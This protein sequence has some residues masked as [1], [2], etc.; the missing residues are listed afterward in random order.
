MLMDPHALSQGRA[1]LLVRGGIAFLIGVVI[2]NQ[3]GASADALMTLFGLWALLEGAATIRQA[4]AR[5]D[6]SEK[7]AARPVLLV[8]GGVA[9]VS[10]L[11]AIFGLGLSSKALTW[12]LA[13]W[14]IV[15]VGFEVWCAIV[16]PLI[17]IRVLFALSALVDVA[18]VAFLV[19]HTSGSVSDL[20]LVGG[21]IVALW[22]VI[23]LV[24]GMAASKVDLVTAAGPRLLQSH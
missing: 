11:L 15:R 3:P 12:V 14:I 10:G 5:V 17:R 9:V 24:I 20:A 6:Q 18:L 21:A 4:Y 1:M 13:A 2:S 22:G 7:I 23:T 16:A 19:T 8:L